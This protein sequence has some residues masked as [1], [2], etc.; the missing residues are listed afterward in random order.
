MPMHTVNEKNKFD[1]KGCQVIVVYDLKSFHLRCNVTSFKYLTCY[2][3]N[4]VSRG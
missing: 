3:L 1:L 4:Y 2:A